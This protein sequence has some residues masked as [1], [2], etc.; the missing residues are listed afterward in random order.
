[1]K[2]LVTGGAGFIGSWVVKGLLMRGHEVV[3]LDNLSNGRLENIKRSMELYPGNLTFV[4]GDIKDVGLMKSLFEEN[5][6]DICFHLAASINVQDSIDNPVETFENDTVGAFNVME[7]CRRHSP[8]GA[9]G[10][11]GAEG[12]AG[13]DGADGAEG[14]EG[15]ERS[16]GAEGA[17]GKRK[18]CKMVFMSTCMVYDKAGMGDDSGICERH[19]TKASS[20]Y[21][22]SKI[23]AENIIMSYWHTYCHP[24]TIVRPFNTYGPYQKTGGEG[25]VIAI[26]IKNALDGSPLSIYGDGSQTRDFLYVEDCAEFVIKAG[27]SN[28]TDGHVLN[29]GLGKDITINQLA[30]MVG[31]GSSCIKHV[32]HIHPQSEIARLLCNYGKAKDLLGWEPKTNLEEGLRHT[33]T[34]IEGNYALV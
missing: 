22:G 32:E 18:P 26:F 13:V 28:Q 21:A 5:C 1:M 27:L 29:A 2:M 10:T 7:Q 11:E 16:E 6:F 19:P 31:G 23:A 30:G 25:G 14:A 20:P 34:W 24:V 12:V 33:R 8:A 4:E 3:V 17:E 15:L 9:T